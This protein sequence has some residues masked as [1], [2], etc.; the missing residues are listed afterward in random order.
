MAVARVLPTP[1]QGAVDRWVGITSGDADL[2]PIDDPACGP[3]SVD[4]DP[5]SSAGGDAHRRDGGRRPEDRGNGAKND[6]QRADHPGQGGAHQGEN[7]AVDSDDQ[8]QNPSAADRGRRDEYR[9]DTSVDPNDQ[10]QGPAAADRGQG[11]ERRGGD[12]H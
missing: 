8:G 5:H 4:A 3:I 6:G 2:T 7:N 1:L 9:D 11:D 10:G 12:R